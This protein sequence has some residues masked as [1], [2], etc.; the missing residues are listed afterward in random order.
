MTGDH[1]NQLSNAAM[2]DRTLK[3][4]CQDEIGPYETDCYKERQRRGAIHA[5]IILRKED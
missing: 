5:H 1:T 3:G 4:S 2:E